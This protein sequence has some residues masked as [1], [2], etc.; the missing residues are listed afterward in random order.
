M[1]KLVDDDGVE[2]KVGDIVSTFRGERVMIVG[3]E[4][5]REFGK[6]GYIHARYLDAQWVN[7]WYPSVI[8]ARFVNS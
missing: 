6:S 1:M 8:N 2:L 5:P 3:L 7:H 4:E